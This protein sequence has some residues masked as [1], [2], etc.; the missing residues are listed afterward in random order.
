MRQSHRYAVSW[1]IASSA[2]LAGFLPQSRPVPPK[3]TPE[4]VLLVSGNT[5]GYLSPCGC[6][7]P[8]SGGIKRRGQLLKTLTVPG[9]TVLLETGRFTDGNSIQD[10]FKAEAMADAISAW[11]A[12]GVAFS[13]VEQAWS[14]DQQATLKSLASDR[15]L[16]DGE[17]KLGPFRV[18]ASTE[19]SATSKVGNVVILDG[20]RDEA[21]KFARTHPKLQLLIYRQQG[22]PDAA[23]AK[24]G[25]TWLVSPGEK[26]KYVLRLSYIN[27]KFSDYRVFGLGPDV[28]DDPVT[29]AIFRRFQRR[30][31]ASGLIDQ[32]PRPQDSAFAGNELCSSCHES[33]AKSWKTSA[34]AH[35]LKTLET[36][37]D[38]RDP[39]CAP[40]HVVG[41]DNRQGFRSRTE[42]P[43]L[44]DVGCESCH[45]AGRAHSDKPT[46][47]KMGR[48]G[49]SKCLSCHTSNTSPNFDFLT[50][51]RKIDHGMGKTGG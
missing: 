9:K 30:V 2:L 25:N 27:G 41:L 40:C 14:G 26:G 3:L 48:V 46:L 23:P 29:T 18:T 4:W 20:D 39:E 17:N 13:R 32:L 33:A 12:D 7:K 36:S 11:K 45:G 16:R 15:V 22:M 49:E 44:T 8:M 5:E 28:A 43:S 6:S 1:G 50:Y 42:T 37:G 34:H 21:E 35:A 19:N 24:I 38:D 47:V 51:W 31:A 10:R